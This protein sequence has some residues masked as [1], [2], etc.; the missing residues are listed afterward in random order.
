MDTRSRFLLVFDYK[1]KPALIFGGFTY[2]S[3]NR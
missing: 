2:D 3:I 1:E